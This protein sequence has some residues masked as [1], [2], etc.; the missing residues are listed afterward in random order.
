MNNYNSYIYF[1]DLPLNESFVLN[2]YK[3]FKRSKTTAEIIS[4]D[5]DYFRYFKQKELVIVPNAIQTLYA[6]K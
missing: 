1:K 6:N 2:G 5:I 4:N 3:W